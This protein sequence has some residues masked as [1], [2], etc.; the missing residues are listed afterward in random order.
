[1][2]RAMMMIVFTLLLLVITASSV[3]L[4]LFSVDAFSVFLRLP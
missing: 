4:S 1:M 3:V 2:I